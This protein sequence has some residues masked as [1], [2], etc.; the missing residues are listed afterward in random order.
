MFNLTQVT[1]LGNAGVILPE[2]LRCQTQDATRIPA[3]EAR[4]PERLSLAFDAD[5][6]AGL[7]LFFLYIFGD[8]QRIRLF[9]N[10]DSRAPNPGFTHH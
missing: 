9:D 4:I 5:C 2:R 10:R 1:N 3:P 8:I 7:F 6:P